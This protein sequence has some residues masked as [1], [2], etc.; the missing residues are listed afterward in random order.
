MKLISVSKRLPYGEYDSER[1]KYYTCYV[2]GGPASFVLNL[3]VE[4]THDKS[5]HTM[6]FQACMKHSRLIAKKINNVG[7]LEYFPETLDY[8]I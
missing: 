1:S 8:L 5:Q 3:L 2:C 4:Y 6:E 7:N